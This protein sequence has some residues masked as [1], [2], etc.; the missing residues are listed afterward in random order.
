MTLCG[1]DAVFLY[2]SRSKDAPPGRGVGEELHAPEATY[3]ALG[4]FPDWR[5]AL[6]NFA[7]S[8]FIL[9]ALTWG[10]V[11]HFFQASKFVTL[12]PAYYRSFSVDSGSRLGGTHGAEI[13]SA[14]GKRGL[15]LGAADRAHWEQIKD[16]V[17]RRA[18]LAKFTQNAEH[19]AILLATGLAKL[20]HRPLRASHTRVEVELMEVRARLRIMKT[21]P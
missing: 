19:Q 15:P 21:A 17:M 1:E 4:R 18:L 5:R 16:D 11:E 7:D 2:H 14:G 20:T 3:A 12:E 9:D 13:K 8:P 6:S 10:S